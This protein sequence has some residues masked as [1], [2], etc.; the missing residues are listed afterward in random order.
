M[1]DKWMQTYSGKKFSFPVKTSM[2]DIRDIAQALSQTCRYNGHTK[3]FY[4][5][6]Q[7]CC[8]IHDYLLKVDTV[9]V[10]YTG[11][12]HDCA[13]AYVGDLVRPLKA[14]VGPEFADLESE[15]ER[16]AAEKF[17]FIYPFPPVVNEVDVAILRAE[18]ALMSEPPEKWP[19][20]DLFPGH[21]PSIGTNWSPPHAA[22]QFMRRFKQCMQS[23]T[24]KSAGKSTPQKKVKQTSDPATGRS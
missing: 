20:D 18:Q 19:T 11:L 12:M 4:S 17:G 2:F 10:A 22:F 16:V 24:I 14:L 5:V 6:A 7:H 1:S 8:H 21:N 13:E 9:E 15:V 3:N 23:D